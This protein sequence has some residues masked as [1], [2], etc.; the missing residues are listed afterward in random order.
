[1]SIKRYT[2]DGY[3]QIEINNCA[4]RRDGRIEAQC[5]LDTTDFASVYA[6]NG[7]LLAVNNVARKVQFVDSAEENPV[8]INYS[9]E[10]NYSSQNPGLKSFKLGL[11]D[12]Y[13]RL[14]YLDKGDKFTT[15]CFSYDST[16]FANDAAVEAIKLVGAG[17]VSVY[18]SEYA[19][20]DG[21]ILLKKTSAPSGVQVLLKVIDVTTMPDGSFAL[22][23]QVI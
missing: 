16:D 23:F 18:G 8:A 14:G 7:M 13:P 21:T 9:S 2:I 15:N 11:N 10:Y 6:E 20:G 19:T 22:K 1:M 12:F 4:F 17:A 3:G 5:G